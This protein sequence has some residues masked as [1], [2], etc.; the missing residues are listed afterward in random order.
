MRLKDFVSA[1]F[2]VVMNLALRLPGHAARGWVLAHFARVE[3]GHACAFQ[4]KVILTTRG[5]VSIGRNCNIN[6]GVL[7]DGRGGLTIGARVNISSDVLLLTAD[8][9]PRSPTFMGRTREI[10]VGDR[11]WIAT[12]AIILPGSVI[13]EGAIVAAGAVVHGHVAPWTIVAGN[14]ASVVG[15]RPRNAQEE[16]IHYAR[17]LQ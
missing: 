16:M 17:F 8:H 14:P 2:L 11:S 5:G 9:D 12:R 1:A 15:D 10:E 6:S 3:M 13:G 7:L 4:R